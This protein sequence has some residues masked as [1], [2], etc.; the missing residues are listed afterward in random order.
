MT[1]K[2]VTAY[3]GSLCRQLVDAF[4]EDLK[5][6][7]EVTVETVAAYSKARR[8]GQSFARLISPLL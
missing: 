5:L 1:V 8:L 4:H 6:A 7:T 2:S 3:E